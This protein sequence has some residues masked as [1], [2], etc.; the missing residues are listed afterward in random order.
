VEL[1]NT[2]AHRAHLDNSVKRIGE[3]LF[4]FE[5]GVEKLTTVRP[6]GQVLVD[7]WACLKSMVNFTTK[8]TCG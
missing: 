1:V 8:R 7:D 2:L 4:G 6:A 3:L 5:N